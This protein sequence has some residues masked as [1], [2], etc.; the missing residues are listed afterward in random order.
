MNVQT[1]WDMIRSFTTFEEATHFLYNYPNYGKMITIPE[2]MTHRLV[3]TAMLILRFPNEVL[4][5]ANYDE[6]LKVTSKQLITGMLDKE[7]ESR[8]KLRAKAFMHI[9]NLWKKQ[10]KEELLK[11]LSSIYLTSRN[12]LFLISQ[13][14]DI[15]PEDEKVRKL[16]EINELEK[17]MEKIKS[18]INTL[19]TKFLESYLAT[20]KEPLDVQKEVLNQISQTMYKTFWSMMLEDLQNGNYEP[21][22]KNLKEAYD[23]LNYLAKLDF[24]LEHYKNLVEQKV[25]TYDDLNKIAIYFVQECKTRGAPEDDKY[26]D[27]ELENWLKKTGSLPNLFVDFLQLLFELVSRINLRLYLLTQK[28]TE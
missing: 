7:D 15:L 4:N 28:I 24:D 20:Q 3:I 13:N 26:A 18:S 2:G 10:D 11:Y 5:N 22:F 1:V 27:Q 8:L 19:D 25:F 17:Y 14:L 16:E 23:T 9:F 12:T 6:F 21:A